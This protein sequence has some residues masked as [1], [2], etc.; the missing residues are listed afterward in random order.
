MR[1]ILFKSTV[2]A[3]SE[4]L[5][6]QG[7]EIISAP[8]CDIIYL[9]GLPVASEGLLARIHWMLSFEGKI[10]VRNSNIAPSTVVGAQQLSK[11]SALFA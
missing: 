8:E 7:T 11:Y 5:L 4:N 9:I 6:F 2:Q 10:H 1:G 3:L